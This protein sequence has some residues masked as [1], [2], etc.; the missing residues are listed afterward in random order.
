MYYIVLSCLVFLFSFLVGYELHCSL[1]LEFVFLCSCHL[2]LRTTV[3]LF[4]CLII[5]L[6]FFGSPNPSGRIGNGTG[7]S[8]S[9]GLDPLDIEHSLECFLLLGSHSSLID[10]SSGSSHQ[11]VIDIRGRNG[12][13]GLYPR[14]TH[15]HAV[16]R[17]IPWHTRR[18]Y[19]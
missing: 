1:S 18:S 7:H 6:V 2:L 4:T 15:K 12:G 10:T 16:R 11:F 14:C 8:S 17:P 5:S 3:L 13:S 19:L 9:K